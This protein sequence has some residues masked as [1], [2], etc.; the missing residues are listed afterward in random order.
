MDAA[1][2]YDGTMLYHCNA[3]FTSNYSGCSGV[4]CQ[5][6]L[7]VGQK[8]NDSTFNKLRNIKL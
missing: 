5:A 3:Y 8:Q 4:T 1:I 7:G 6:K 2:T